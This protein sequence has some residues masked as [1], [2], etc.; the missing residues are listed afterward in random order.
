MG[1]QTGLD[2]FVPQGFLLVDESADGFFADSSFIMHDFIL[3]L[4]NNGPSNE[5]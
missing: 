5:N 1:R 4:L 3:L 2:K